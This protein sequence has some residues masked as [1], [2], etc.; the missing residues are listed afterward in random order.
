[1]EIEYTFDIASVIVG[2]LIVAVGALITKYYNKLADSTGFSNYSRW[3]LAG[4]IIIG[5]GFL[6]MAS[7]HIFLLKLLVNT[8]I[9]GGF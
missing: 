8:I 6:V 7:L 1:M 3:R 2:V 9:G 5:I 4:F